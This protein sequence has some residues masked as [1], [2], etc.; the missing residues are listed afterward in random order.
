MLGDLEERYSYCS[1]NQ[2]REHL[3]KL[4]RPPS[5]TDL[6]VLGFSPDWVFGFSL[7]R[8]LG[9]S[10]SKTLGFS[11]VGLSTTSPHG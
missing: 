2:D 3:S 8:T 6:Q 11:Q 9:F 5:S 4:T 10:P 1:Y 7:G